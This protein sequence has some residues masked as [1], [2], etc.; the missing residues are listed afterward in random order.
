MSPA[1][2]L[3]MKKFRS[4]GSKDG[5]RGLELVDEAHPFVFSVF[6]LS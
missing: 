1:I 2:S 3:E 5:V 6:Q 4:I